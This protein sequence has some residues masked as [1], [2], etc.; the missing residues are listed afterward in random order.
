MLAAK[1]LTYTATSVVDDVEI[2]KF[3]AII[4]VEDGDLSFFSQQL[5]KEACKQH[6]DIVRA[7][8]AEFEDFAYSIQEMIKTTE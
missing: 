1:K 4:R 5:D 6:R 3:G 7:D 2:A 8:H